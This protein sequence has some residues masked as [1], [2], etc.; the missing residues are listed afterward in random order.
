MVSEFAGGLTPGFRAFAGPSQIVTGPDGNL[1]F[2]E[3][4]APGAIAYMDR[5]GVVHELTRGLTANNGP[6]GIAAGPDG[7]VW[8]TEFGT[9]SP[10]L[11]YVDHSGVVHEF[12]P[13]LTAGFTGGDPYNLTTGPDG[14]VWFTEAGMNPGRI[15][16]IDG[17][18]VVHE[19]ATH[20]TAYGIASGPGR[21]VWFTELS[22]P[23][24]V[25]YIDG[26]GV[27]HEF[28]GGVTTGF[29]ADR[30]P[31]AITVGPD[32]HI[33]FAELAAPKGVAYIDDAGVVHE[34]TPNN[35]PGFAA[36]GSINAIATGPDGNLWFA[37]S[38][39][40]GRLGRVN[41]TGGVPTG[42][43]TEFQAGDVS[44]LAP[45]AEPAGITTGPDGHI[46]F[47]DFGGPGRVGRVNGPD[48]VSGAGA[49]SGPNS[50][51]LSGTVNP[52][53]TAVTD[54]HFEFGTNSGYGTTIPCAPAPGGGGTSDVAVSAD[55]GSLLPGGTYHFRAVA[56]NVFGTSIGSD[57]L[58]RMPALVP[59]ASTGPA[60][61]IGADAAI[62]MGSVV[63]NG[64]SVTDCHYDYGTSTSY[65]SSA[66]CAQQVG[67]GNDAVPVSATIAGLTPNT[68][69]HVRLV[70]TNRVGTARGAD[71]VFTVGR[72]ATLGPRRPVLS[73][74]RLHPS[75]FPAAHRRRQ[76]TG[77]TISYRDT[78]R[79]TTTFTIERCLTPRRHRPKRCAILGTFTHADR[80]GV[81]RLHFSG[82]AAGKPLAP[83]KYTLVVVA[84]AA[85]TRSRPATAQFEVT[86]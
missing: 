14:H 85:G 7:N 51:T 72:L 55:V 22:D 53:G 41:F 69:Y 56:R 45:D 12:A 35:T 38:G 27:V 29:P 52:N 81:N 32:G 34:L 42:T 65:G 68:T 16:Y 63:P 4:Q 1:W 77:T 82:H 49:A 44:G 73:R 40:R 67:A 3:H 21:H 33:W 59:S 78:A 43:V 30:G 36:G 66:P 24:R 86:R 39:T 10:R 19:F 11:A 48:A 80:P 26:N 54:C 46:W 83:G 47:T 79:A 25:G 5:T 64:A 61:A 2:T 15:A 58:L 8:F 84:A 17:N 20:G 75:R 50:A 76:T 9:P 28:T 13:G 71:V 62:V 6:W 57:A 74:L 18:A 60:A 37:E 23:G 70:A 31:A